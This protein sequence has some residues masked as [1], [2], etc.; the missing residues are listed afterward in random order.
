M[1]Q[2]SSERISK[3]LWKTCVTRSWW[4]MGEADVCRTFLRSLSVLQTSSKHWVG[5]WNTMVV[6]GGKWRPF[7][8]R[9]PSG[10]TSFSVSCEVTSR[11][12]DLIQY[13]GNGKWGHPRWWP[14]AERPPFSTIHHHGVPKTHP[15][16]LAKAAIFLFVCSFVF[17][18][19]VF[20]LGGGGGGGCSSFNKLNSVLTSEI[21]IFS[22]LHF[23]C[24]CVV[25]WC[26]VVFL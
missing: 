25:T 18:L 20:F 23:C 24:A 21:P 22:R 19:F 3:Y 1:N 9:S 12:S 15:I 2:T 4:V 7:R 17:C 16:L 13:G 14:E 26:T 5:F 10:M 8:F 11:G 6:D